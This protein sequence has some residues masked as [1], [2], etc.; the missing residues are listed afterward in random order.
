MSVTEILSRRAALSFEVFPP[1]TESAMAALCG[2]GGVLDQLRS[3][4]PDYIA[5]TY[6]AGGTDAGKNLEILDKVRAGGCVPVTQF[7]CAGNTRE[8]A[9][10]Q[11]Q[12]YLDHGVDHII[13]LRGVAGTGKA[14]GEL[15]NAADLVDF[16]RQTFG[17]RFTIAVAA[18][19]GGNLTG[20]A[21]EAELDFLKRRQDGGADFIVT[22]PCWDMDQFRYWLDAIRAAGIWLPVEA[23]VLPLLDQTAAINAAFS[24][25]GCTMS[26][27]LNELLGQNWIYPNPFTKDPF[28]ARIEQK[29][30]DFREAGIEY[31]VNQ[32]NAYRAC[33]VGGIHLLTGNSCADAARIVREA[34]LLDR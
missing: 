13:A 18:A 5:C 24:G 10:G 2:E 28:D 3:L 31:T 7:T 6:G 15:R 17:G 29:R 4:N 1:K 33:G 32:I 9:R 19:P 12:N 22:Q 11:L 25:S 26:R 8:S 14:D 34:G 30:A 21:P 20:E 27:E 16:A 23:G